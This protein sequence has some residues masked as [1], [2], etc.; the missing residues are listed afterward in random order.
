[1][2]YCDIV[3]CQ[4]NA[5]YL[6]FLTLGLNYDTVERGDDTYSDPILP[7]SSFPFEFSFTFERTIYVSGHVTQRLQ[8]LPKALVSARCLVLHSPAS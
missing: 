1:L 5:G 7:S 2:L 3:L 6:N 8:Q 4:Q